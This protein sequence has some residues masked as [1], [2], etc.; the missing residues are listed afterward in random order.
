MPGVE[1][2]HASR[3]LVKAAGLVAVAIGVVVAPNVLNSYRLFLGSLII[4]FAIAGAG[5]VVIMGW[6]G[7]I[8]L[9]HVAFFGIGVYGTNW[10]FGDVGIPWAVAL[11]LS[12]LIAAIV[13][14]LIGFPAARLRGFY[15]AIATLAF[16]ELIAGFFVEADWITGGI[17]GTSIERVQLFGLSP[18]R[19]QWYLGAIVAVIV[20]WTLRRLGSTAFGRCSAD[21]SRRRGRHGIARHLGDQVQA[22]GVP[23]SAFVAAVAGGL[24]GQLLTYASPDT[25]GTTL[26]IQFLVVAFVGGVTRL[27]GAVVGAFFVIVSR[28]LLQDVGDWQRLVF[29]LSLVL[30]MRFLPGGLTSLGAGS[31]EPLPHRPAQTRPSIPDAVARPRSGRHMKTSLGCS[32]VG[33]RG[34]PVATFAGA[35]RRASWTGS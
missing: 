31:R 14:A 17:A 11:V 13:G 7:Q 18:D 12:A 28:E 22:S 15:L 5:L 29:G 34:S 2:N 23:L 4:V 35:P 8:A 10:L 33:P 19:S 20:F 32:S 24:F 25:F 27:S 6:T 1:T 26:L 21:R 9:A 30:T 16:A 3:V